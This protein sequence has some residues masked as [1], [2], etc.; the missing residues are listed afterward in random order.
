M[1]PTTQALP[2]YAFF[3]F[4]D[5]NVRYV[6]LGAV[7]LTAISAVVG[8]FTFL[9]R[10]ALVGDAVAHAVLPGVCLAFLL[11]GTKDPVYLLIGAASTGWLSLWTMDWITHY[12]RIREDTAIGLVLSV[13]FGLGILILTYIQKHGPA[14]QSGLD[15]FLFGQAAALIGKDLYTF[16]SVA[17]ILLLATLLFYKEF[18]L[19]SFDPAYASTLGLPVRTLEL[20]L[21][22]LTVLAVV[23]GIQ[24]V[25][26][27]LMAAMLITPAAAAR[28]W[29][30]NLRNMLLLAALLGAI[31]GFAGAFIS[32]TA[33]AMPTGPWIVLVVSFIAFVSFLL[34]PGKGMA[35][36]WIRHRQNRR[37]ILE[38][39]ILKTFY[40]LGEADNTF[41]AVRS[42]ADL[43]SRRPMH[44]RD[45]EHGLRRLVRRQ[46]IRQQDQGWKVS[47]S[48]YRRGKAITKLH[49]LWELYLANYLKLQADHVHE[50][51]EIIEHVIT[52]EIEAALLELL[53][54]PHIDPHGR[55]IPY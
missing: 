29:T 46:E 11:S 34:A 18:K 19:I 24:A 36:R 43:L 12:S 14:G 54:H 10:R 20:I 37:R 42:R 49:R 35:A 30:H 25:G 9:R 16:G 3:S 23:I 26:V 22:T 55:E 7:L 48:G 27:V 15:T 40:H 4:A 33:P 41:Y 51:A 13:F 17:G 6:T 47:E 39:N 8:C 53:E 32:F 38:E 45:L 44:K 1:L 50:D 52:P 5:P 28:F 31:S 21:S 2:W